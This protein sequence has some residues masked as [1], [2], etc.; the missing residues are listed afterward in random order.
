MFCIYLLFQC[1]TKLAWGLGLM[2]FCHEEGNG[3]L[4]LFM[5]S[6][7][8]IF[9]KRG[10]SSIARNVAGG[11]ERQLLQSQATRFY[12]ILIHHLHV[13]HNAPYFPP[14]IW[15]KLFLLLFL[16]GRL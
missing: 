5:F 16:L 6:N 10:K 12:L 13:S 7:N 2:D 1:C 14:K 11:E 9:Q 15:H 8:L 3:K 4:L